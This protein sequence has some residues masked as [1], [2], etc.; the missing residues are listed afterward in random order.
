M[1]L[2]DEYLKL[3]RY[4]EVVLYPKKGDQSFGKASKELKCNDLVT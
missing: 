1:K 4:L 2:L 3:G